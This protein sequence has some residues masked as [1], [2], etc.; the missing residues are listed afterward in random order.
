VKDKKIK[1]LM[2]KELLELAVKLPPRNDTFGEA[3]SE[4]APQRNK[5]VSGEKGKKRIGGNLKNLTK[6]K[7]KK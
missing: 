5:K 2:Q 6:K 4:R 7:K 3:Y 1:E